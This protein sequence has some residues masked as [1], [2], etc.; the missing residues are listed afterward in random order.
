MRKITLFALLCLA[1]ILVAMSPIVLAQQ[2]N[3][4]QTASHE[5][6]GALGG[7][8]TFVILPFSDITN[9]YFKVGSL[10]V[11][12]GNVKGLGNSNLFTFHRPTEQ[13]GVIDGRFFIVAANGDTI[14]GEYEGTTGPGKDACHLV[15]KAVWKITSGTGRFADA[16][17]EINATAYVTIAPNPGGNP[18][19]NPTAFE[20]P[21]TWVLEGMINY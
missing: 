6:E 18:P 20:W 1:A 12:S 15:G 5:I 21:V 2:N 8:F 14:R 11:V 17:G 9:P 10:G 4:T 19:C 16:E 7:T 3:R 13:G